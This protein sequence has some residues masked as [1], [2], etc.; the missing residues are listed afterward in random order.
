MMLRVKEVIQAQTFQQNRDL[1]P[2]TLAWKFL[3]MI[4]ATCAGQPNFQDKP[5]SKDKGKKKNLY[6]E[7][8]YDVYSYHSLPFNLLLAVL[9]CAFSV[10]HKMFLP[11][12]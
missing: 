3:K 4:S 9:C 2:Q 6:S 11:F 10:D 1:S 7:G 5:K 8:E 12:T